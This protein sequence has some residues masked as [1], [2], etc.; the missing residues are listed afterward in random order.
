VFAGRKE[1]LFI[2]KVKRF[3]LA[4]CVII[5]EFARCIYLDISDAYVFKMI[6]YAGMDPA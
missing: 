2:V 6:N 5:Y 4:K 1:T 3:P